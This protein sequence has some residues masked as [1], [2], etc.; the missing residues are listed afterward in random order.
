MKG[1][2]PPHDL[3][4]AG[5]GMPFGDIDAELLGCHTRDPIELVHRR[6][7]VPH[8]RSHIVALVSEGG[9]LED[10]FVEAFCPIAHVDDGR[11][12]SGWSGGIG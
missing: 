2:S 12:G 5:E 3:L 7:L 8:E 10:V 11:N 4:V 1:E 9:K 6:D